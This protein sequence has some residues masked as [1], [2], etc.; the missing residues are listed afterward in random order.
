MYY[1]LGKDLCA[2]GYDFFAGSDFHKPYVKEGEPSLH[3]QAQDAGYTI[4]KGYKEY[5]KKGRKADKLILIQSDKQ[6]EKLDSEQLPY[7]QDQDKN[8]LTLEQITRAGIN[9]LM[10]KNK[11]GFFFAIEG[12]MI[13]WA[14]H[15]NDIGCCINEVLDMDKAVKV[16]YEFYQQHPD[17]TIIVISADH[18]TGGMAMGVGPYE[19][20][21]DLLKYQRKSIVELKWILKE[22]YKKAPKKFTWGA[23]EK[24]LKDLM[25]FGAGINLKDEQKER[26]QNRWKAIE[27]A[28]A[29]N[30]KV[31]N[32][33]DDLCETTKHILSEVAMISWASGGHSNGYVPVYAVGPGTEI[34]QG[35]ID[36]IEIAPGIAKIAGY[37][38]E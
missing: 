22:Q 1:E 13:D 18:E 34:F 6:N 26:L 27:K 33:I 17:E 32:R 31:E 10:N 35:R 28:I 9:Y 16:A 36:N 23:V 38:A 15:R 14:C 37:E 7:A 24:Q 2:S 25:G 5:E 8:D 11:D 20:H 21:T 4:V 19:I 30:N 12:G 3:Q 29:E